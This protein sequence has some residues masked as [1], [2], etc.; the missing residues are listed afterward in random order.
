MINDDTVEGHVEKI[1][2][3]KIINTTQSMKTEKASG[4]SEINFKMIA[5]SGQ[6]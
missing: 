2:L 5:A 1:S 3:A 4:Y 6:L